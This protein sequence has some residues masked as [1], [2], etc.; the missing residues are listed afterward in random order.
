MAVLI[1]TGNSLPNQQT[2][3]YART[4]TVQLQL[5]QR[6]RWRRVQAD[7]ATT[8]PRT[9]PAPA[10]PVW[11]EPPQEAAPRPGPPFCPQQPNF[12]CCCPA[13]LSP[14]S[15][16]ILGEAPTK[17]IRSRLRLRVCLWRSSSGAA[18][19]RTNISKLNGW[20]DNRFRCGRGYKNK[21]TRDGGES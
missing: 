9:T 10:R 8:H 21:S 12:G 19:R 18:N 15:C 6:R 20:R 16:G 3:T 14:S 11:P 4:H 5:Q 7:R 13:S 17:Y 2:S 1:S